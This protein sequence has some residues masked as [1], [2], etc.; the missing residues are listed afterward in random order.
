MPHRSYPT[1]RSPSSAQQRGHPPDYILCAKGSRSLTLARS[2]TVRDWPVKQK[3]IQNTRAA[4]NKT[5][6]LPGY[7]PVV[8]LT[9]EELSDEL[10]RRG[11]HNSLSHVKVVRTDQRASQVIH[12]T[13]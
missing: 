2:Y 7:Q 5:R 9:S 11:A 4:A 6:S 3:Q 13:I 12:R 1:H 8:L 10:R